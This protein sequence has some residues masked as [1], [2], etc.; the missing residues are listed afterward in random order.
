M[1]FDSELLNFPVQRQCLRRIQVLGTFQ[2]RILN[3]WLYTERNID[4]VLSDPA[5]SAHS[6]ARLC[7]FF[8]KIEIRVVEGKP[9]KSTCL[10]HIIYLLLKCVKAAKTQRQDY[11]L[12]RQTMERK[13]RDASGECQCL[14]HC[15]G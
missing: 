13:T 15:K 12:R 5:E 8:K 14:I 3:W 7:D 6:A 11:L 9:I 10:Y 2:R 1:S 4:I